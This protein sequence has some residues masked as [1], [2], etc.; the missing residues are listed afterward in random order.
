MSTPALAAG[1]IVDGIHSFPIRVYYEDTD[2]AGIVY[3][4]NYLKFAERARTEMLRELGFEHRAM[5]RET[6]LGLAVRRCAVEY[7]APAL[8]DDALEVRTCVRSAAGATLE[9]EQEVCRAGTV[10]TRLVL[11]IA[12]V[13]GAGRPVRLPPALAAAAKRF[14]RSASTMVP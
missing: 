7:F 5:A 6:G 4:A 8:L 10:L 14:S 3:Y 1:V 9:L 12:C 13:N 2:A 11:T